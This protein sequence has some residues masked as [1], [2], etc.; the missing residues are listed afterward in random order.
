M[1]SIFKEVLRFLVMYR[2]LGGYQRCIWWKVIDCIL[3]S[4]FVY[5]ELPDEV[6]V[7]SF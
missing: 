3:K 7:L 6:G 1:T 4:I 5:S 2:V